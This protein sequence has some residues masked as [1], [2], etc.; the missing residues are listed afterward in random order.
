MRQNLKDRYGM[1]L[2][3]YED[4]NG[5]KELYDRYGMKLGYYDGRYTYDK[6]G[7]RVGEGDLLAMLLR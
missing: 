1:L 7:M 6:Y 2:G 5:K 4:R 3:Y